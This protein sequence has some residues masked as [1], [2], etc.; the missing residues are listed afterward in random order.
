MTIIFDAVSTVN[1]EYCTLSM[2]YWSLQ[3]YQYPW[4][5]QIHF[6]QT[7]TNYETWDE[8]QSN[9]ADQATWRNSIWNRIKYLRWDR[10]WIFFII[11]H[12][13]W[14][15]VINSFINTV[16]GIHSRQQC[17]SGNYMLMRHK[18]HMFTEK[19]I[20][21]RSILCFLRTK[22]SWLKRWTKTYS[23]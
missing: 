16:K 1:A 22:H 15:M 9:R 10:Q 7:C 6:R 23:D 18:I 12:R 5:F 17:N 20:S 11:Y 21:T 8:D 13:M 2:H 3:Y 14:Q 19:W 4:A